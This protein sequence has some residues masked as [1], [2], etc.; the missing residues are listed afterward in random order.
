MVVADLSSKWS[1]VLSVLV[2]VLS[3]ALECPDSSPAY[4]EFSELL[5]AATALHLGYFTASV[6]Y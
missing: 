2:E 3:N 4:A 6:V 1:L 5:P